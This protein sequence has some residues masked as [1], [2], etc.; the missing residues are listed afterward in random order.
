MFDIVKPVGKHPQVYGLTLFLLRF[1]TPQETGKTKELP[2]Q[3][4][5]ALRQKLRRSKPP[6]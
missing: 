3:A 6:S 2:S 1:Y 4:A 5:R